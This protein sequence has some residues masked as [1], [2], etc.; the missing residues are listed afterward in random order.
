MEFVMLYADKRMKKEAQMAAP[1]LK[2][3]AIN[4][5]SD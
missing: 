5:L 2:G 1:F 3:A 4:N